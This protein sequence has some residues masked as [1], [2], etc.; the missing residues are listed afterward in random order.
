MKMQERKCM[1]KA[2]FEAL[3]PLIVAS[4]LQKIINRKKI[5]QDE[6]FSQ[7]YSSRLYSVLDE[8]K[9]KCGITA[10]INFISFLKKKKPP[11]NWSFRSIN[12]G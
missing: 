12:Y 1:D 7:L 8:E 10:Q 5:S 11:G 9:Q 3:L 2:K 6:A 4:L